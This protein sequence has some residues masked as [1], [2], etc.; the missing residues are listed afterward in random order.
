MNAHESPL[1]Q[2]LAAIQSALMAHHAGGSEMSSATAGGERET[3]VRKFLTEVFPADLRFATGDIIDAS[4]SRSGQVDIAIK[5]GF[6]PSFPMP[7]GE[8]RLLL[9]DAVAMVI[10]VKSDLSKQWTEIEKK[11]RQV[12]ALKR[13]LHVQVHFGDKPPPTIPVIAVGY[14]GD[15]TVKGLG[16]RLRSTDSDSRPDGALVIESGCFFSFGL[17]T[18][19][20]SGLYAICVYINCTLN[21]VGFAWPN[22]LA[23]VPIDVR[24]ANGDA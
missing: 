19:G 8:Q 2:R 16:D 9:A 21:R 13:D 12:K 18:E 5:Y 7:S 3:F 1:I 24:K 23:Y 22:L 4:G 10:E 15:N 14:T 20:P 11:T 6:L 17:E